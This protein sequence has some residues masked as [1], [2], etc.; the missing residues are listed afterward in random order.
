MM[1]SIRTRRPVKIERVKV[2][3][4]DDHAIVREGLKAVLQIDPRLEVVGEASNGKQA[5]QM[6]RSLR[7]DVILMDLVMPV[8]DG[9][10][11]TRQIAAQWQSSKV[12]VLSSYPERDLVERA[13]AAGATGYLLKH[14]ASVEVLKA[15]HQIHKG[16]AFFSSAISRMLT[17]FGAA[18]GTSK[19]LSQLHTQLTPRQKEV[20][21]LIAEGNCNKEIASDL[22]ISIKTVEKHRQELMTRLNIHTIAGLTRYALAKGFVKSDRPQSEYELARQSLVPPAP[23]VPPPPPRRAVA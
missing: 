18:P 6:V 23:S 20:L 17:A 3:I 14:S 9:I 2:L 21:R 5:I 22:A 19:N 10:E 1:R 4:V 15:I 7:P 8:M 11:A 12:L 16:A 13:L